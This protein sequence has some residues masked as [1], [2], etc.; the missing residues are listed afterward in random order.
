MTVYD[1]RDLDTL[2]GPGP[3][4]GGTQDRAPGS[5]SVWGDLT[6][7]TPSSVPRKGTSVCTWGLRRSRAVPAQ[8]TSLQ[9]GTW[10]T[11]DVQGLHE[12]ATIYPSPVRIA[13]GRALLSGLKSFLT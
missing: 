2:K 5:A 1:R 3:L 6:G 10:D 8:F 7:C 11:G 13:N 12:S 9:Q 4:G